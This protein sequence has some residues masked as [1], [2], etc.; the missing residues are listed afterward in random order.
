MKIL[1]VIL[2]EA[3]DL[4]RAPRSF[5]VSVKWFVR[6]FAVFGALVAASACKVTGPYA[7]FHMEYGDCSGGTGVQP[8]SV[9]VIGFP[10]DRVDS[11]DRGVL[12][13]G[14]TVELRLLLME[15]ARHYPGDTSYAVRWTLPSGITA[16][17]LVNAD[18]GVGRLTAM[19]PGSLTFVVADGAQRP[20]WAYTNLVVHKLVRIDIVP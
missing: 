11:L 13:V 8:D 18:N 10:A 2:N 4:G 14:E 9:R 19:A 17:R 20:V 7:C 1:S 12:H 15:N 5:A 3:K 6:W 16:A